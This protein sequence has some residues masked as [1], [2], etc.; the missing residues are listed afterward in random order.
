MINCFFCNCSQY[1][2]CICWSV[3]CSVSVSAFKSCNICTYMYIK[4]ISMTSSAP[5]YTAMIIRRDPANTH[6]GSLAACTALTMSGVMDARA[7]ILALFQSWSREAWP[8]SP[9]TFRR[10]QKSL[11]DDGDYKTKCGRLSNHL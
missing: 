5:M 3:L 2:G 8:R 9:T 11:Q 1:L 6:P 7:I 10:H 4:T